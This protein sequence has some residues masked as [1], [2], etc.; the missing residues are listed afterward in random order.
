MGKKAA[1]KFLISDAWD[2][3]FPGNKKRTCRFALDANL[4]DKPGH[5]IHMFGIKDSKGWRM[6]FRAEAYEVLDS[7]LHANP[8]LLE[9]PAAFGLTE[10]TVAPT[11]DN[12]IRGNSLI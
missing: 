7:L 8:G 9:S 5:L 12:A 6:A 11:W 10:S 1:P 4:I 3:I 2:H